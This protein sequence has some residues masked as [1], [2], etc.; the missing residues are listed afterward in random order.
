M[1][2]YR[3]LP[4][5]YILSYVVVLFLIKQLHLDSNLKALSR[6]VISFVILCPLFILHKDK[7]KTRNHIIYFFRALIACCAVLLTYRVYSMLP[8]TNATSISLSEPLFS[9]LLSFL[10]LREKISVKKWIMLLIGYCGVLI[11]IWPIDFANKYLFLQGLLILANIIMS[12]NS[13][14][15]KQ[16]SVKENM[17]TVLFYLYVYMIPMLWFVN[18]L[19]GNGILCSQICTLANM[20]ILVPAGILGALNNVVMIYSLQRLSVSTFTSA[21]YFRIFLATA[22]SLCIGEHILIKEIIGSIIIIISSAS[23]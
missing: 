9:A 15:I 7:L 20:K 10:I 8:F 17:I 11:S 21:Q 14:I 5:F 1:I 6:F 23:M 3:I 18:V 22:F 19:S 2:I 13:I 12:L 16:L 4:L